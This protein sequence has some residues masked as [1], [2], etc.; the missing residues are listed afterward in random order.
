[1]FFGSA[2]IKLKDVES[3]RKNEKNGKDGQEGGRESRSLVKTAREYSRGI[4]VSR[5]AT[6]FPARSG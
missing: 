3:I 5:T 6:W 4:G 2:Y 1:M